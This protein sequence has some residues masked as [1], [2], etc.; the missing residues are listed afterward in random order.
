MKLPFPFPLPMPW[1]IP[2]LSLIQIITSVLPVSLPSW[3]HPS[4]LLPNVLCQNTLL[5]TWIVH[6]MALLTNSSMALIATDS[7]SPYVSQSWFRLLIIKNSDIWYIS[8]TSTNST[9]PYLLRADGILLTLI[10]QIIM[11]LLA[12][13]GLMPISLYAPW[14]RGLFCCWCLQLLE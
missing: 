13:V 7:F 12:D 5:K 2:L 3:S 8:L 14:K 11:K 4:N 6:A 10:Y 1:F 9:C